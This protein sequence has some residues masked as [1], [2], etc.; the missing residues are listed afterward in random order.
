[1][2]TTFTKHPEIVLYQWSQLSLHPHSETVFSVVTNFN[3]ETSRDSII[4][5][6]N[7]HSTS[8]DSIINDHELHSTSRD[9]IINN[10]NLNLYSTSRDRIINDHNLHSIPETVLSMITTFNPET[11][12]DRII[13][14][15][16]VHSTSR[17]RIFTFQWSQLSIRKHPET[18]LSMITTFTPHP[19]TVFSLFSGHNFQSGNIQRPYYQ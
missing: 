12:R 1:M 18:V 16:N 4:N 15:L 13:N 9:R 5:D 14:D 8:R 3:P 11:S 6:H 17:D 7:L 2:I 19:E 10:H